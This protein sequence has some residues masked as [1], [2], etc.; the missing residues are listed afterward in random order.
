MR[1]L[2]TILIIVLFTN[3][4]YGQKDTLKQKND[5]LPGKYYVLQKVFEM[6]PK[7]SYEFSMIIGSDHANAFEKW[8]QH[9]ELQ[10]L[11]PFIVISRYGA[12]TNNSVD[13]YY[14][15]K[16]LDCFPVTK[17]YM[18]PPHVFLQLSHSDIADISSTQV[19]EAVAD[20]R[21]VTDMVPPGVWE[22]IR[23]RGLYFNARQ[24]NQ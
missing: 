18:Q 16:T 17:W 13:S 23:K 5:T 21:P 11:I 19:R 10:E 12:S 24:A 6:Y 20:R 4:A 1:L 3:N 8:A 15:K 14:R 9:K 7:H 2:F 22:Y